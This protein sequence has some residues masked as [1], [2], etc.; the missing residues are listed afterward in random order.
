[1]NKDQNILKEFCIEVLTYINQT[2][3]EEIPF[4]N[5][6]IRIVSSLKS[7]RDI[8]NTVTEVLEMSQDYSDAKLESLDKILQSKNLPSLTFMRGKASRFVLSIIQRGIIETDDEFRQLNSYLD[9]SIGK[10]ADSQTIEKIN[11]LLFNYEFTK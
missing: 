6:F 7:K 3:R 1:M 8:N 2:E 5:D 11:T 4:M 10:N 9:D